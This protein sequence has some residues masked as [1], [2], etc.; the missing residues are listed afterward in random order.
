MANVTALSL[1][2]TALGVTHDKRDDYYKSLLAA[3]ERELSGRGVAI[4]ESEIDDIMLLVD[5]AEFNYRN[6]DGAKIIPQH[7]DLRIKNRKA[8]G[9]SERGD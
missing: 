6:R 5:Y 3:S 2:K 9:R 7:I 8:K 4:D 1:L